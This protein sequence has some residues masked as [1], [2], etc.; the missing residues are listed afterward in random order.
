VVRSTALP[1]EMIWTTATLK[2]PR[3]TTPLPVFDRPELFAL[4]EAAEAERAWTRDLAEWYWEKRGNR[5]FVIDRELVL[6]GVNPVGDRGWTVE[7]LL[8]WF[9]A[10]LTSIREFSP[11]SGTG[12]P[13]IEAA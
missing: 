3:A 13:I 7:R 12:K 11:R 8:R 6:S 5:D 1:G 4:L 9:D 2:P 10:R